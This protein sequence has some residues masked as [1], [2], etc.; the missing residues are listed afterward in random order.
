VVE[1]VE[2]LSVQPQFHLLGQGEPFGQVKITPDEVRAAK[3]LQGAFCSSRW[4]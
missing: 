2:K 3:P 1:Q 4:L